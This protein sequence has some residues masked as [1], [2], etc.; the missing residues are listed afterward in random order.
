M[1]EKTQDVFHSIPPHCPDIGR[2]K[3]HEESSRYPFMDY[4][5]LTDIDNNGIGLIL[6]FSESI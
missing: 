2:D 3:R 5:D 1:L 6:F 4:D